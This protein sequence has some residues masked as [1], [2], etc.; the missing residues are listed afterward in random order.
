MYGQKKNFYILTKNECFFIIQICNFCMKCPCKLVQSSNASLHDLYSSGSPKLACCALTTGWACV[1]SFNLL[2]S[3][4]NPSSMSSFLTDTPILFLSFLDIPCVYLWHILWW[5]CHSGV[6]WFCSAS[7]CFVKVRDKTLS[8][9]LHCWFHL[10]NH[11]ISFDSYYLG[12][13][14]NP[15]RFEIFSY[16]YIDIF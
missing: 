8:S 10:V 13:W 12:T 5:G 7:W 11:L 14:P 1:I 3:T 15:S 6:S 16:D 9:R 2:H 4:H